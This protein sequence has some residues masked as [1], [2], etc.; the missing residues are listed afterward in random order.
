MIVS[1][2]MRDINWTSFVQNMDCPNMDVPTFENAYDLKSVS[3][4][5]VHMLTR[6]KPCCFTNGFILHK[7]AV[8]QH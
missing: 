7:L 2:T 8:S 3:D 1:F 6:L 4:Q 5:T